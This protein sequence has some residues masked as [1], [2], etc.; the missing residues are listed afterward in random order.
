DGHLVNR[1]RE[2][3]ARTA[4]HRRADPKLVVV[5][6]RRPSR[7][8][9]KIPIAVD[10]LAV[11]VTPDRFR[12][13]KGV[14]HGHV[15]PAAIGGE[16][17]LRIPAMKLGRLIAVRRAAEQKAQPGRTRNAAQAERVVLVV[18]GESGIASTS[19]TN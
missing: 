16:P 18:P 4:A 1:P 7:G 8:A 15:M 5:D 10:G 14:G 13:A 19:L 17:Q 12:L 2:G 9:G 6:H 3:A 11:D